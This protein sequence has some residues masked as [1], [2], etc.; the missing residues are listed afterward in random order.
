MTIDRAARD[1][2]RLRAKN[3]VRAAKKQKTPIQ[4]KDAAIFNMIWALGAAYIF[5]GI[6][7]RGKCRCG[8]PPYTDGNPCNPCEA[9]HLQETLMQVI[10]RA[11]QSHDCDK[12]R[13][14]ARAK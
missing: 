13:R 14:K 11:E 3:A 7:R 4:R 2:Q 1:E 12:K 8:S 5:C 9:V 10:K 6:I